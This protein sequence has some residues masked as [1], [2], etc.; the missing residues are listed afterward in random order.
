[1]T[2]SESTTVRAL[3]LKGVRRAEPLDIDGD[4]EHQHIYARR[5]SIVRTPCYLAVLASRMQRQCRNARA[6][7]WQNRVFGNVLVPVGAALFF[8]RRQSA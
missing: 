3:H 7:R 6:V 4:F 1:M 2:D 8:V 5:I